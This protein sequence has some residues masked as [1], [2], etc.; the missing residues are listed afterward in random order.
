MRKYNNAVANPL[1]ICHNKAN[2][3]RKGEEMEEEEDSDIF[4][5]KLNEEKED[6]FLEKMLKKDKEIE[7][8]RKQKEKD[9]A[10]VLSNNEELKKIIDIKNLNLNSE[11]NKESILNKEKKK[12]FKEKIRRIK[13]I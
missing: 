11:E 7:A 8:L 5:K 4:D 3:E 6:D 13:R 1:S 9:I 10:A 12:L 2:N